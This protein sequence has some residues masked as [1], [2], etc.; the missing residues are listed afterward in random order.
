[1]KLTTAAMALDLLAPDDA[2]KAEADVTSC[3][4]CSFCNC[5][6][7]S[8]LGICCNIYCIRSYFNS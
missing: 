4:L 7:K 1:M 5:G 8:L 3:N 6:E 2:R